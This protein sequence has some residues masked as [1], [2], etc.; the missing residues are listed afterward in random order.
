MDKCLSSTGVDLAGIKEKNPAR[1]ESMKSATTFGAIQKL[2]N[3]TLKYLL[4]LQSFG[5]LPELVKEE[6]CDCPLDSGI[7]KSLQEEAKWTAVTKEEYT[8]IQGEI[9][10]RVSGLRLSYDFANWPP[11]DDEVRNPTLL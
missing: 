8:R 9:D 7:L 5:C 10:E 4:I 2:V 11:E 3:M 1:Y 6:N